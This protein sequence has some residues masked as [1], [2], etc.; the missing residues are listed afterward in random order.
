MD[1]SSVLVA[2]TE[3]NRSKFKHIGYEDG[4]I[5]EQGV[6]FEVEFRMDDFDT[7]KFTV[8]SFF[9]MVCGGTRVFIAPRWNSEDDSNKTAPFYPSFVQEEL[10]ENTSNH[11]SCWR[12]DGFRFI[13]DNWREM[14]DLFDK[15]AK[16]NSYTMLGMRSNPVMDVIISHKSEDEDNSYHRQIVSVT[17]I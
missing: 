16:L 14:H 4:I 11:D 7:E 8:R 1:V 5:T 6:A 13:S 3:S 2:L 9:V 17:R 12:S 15:D 10:W